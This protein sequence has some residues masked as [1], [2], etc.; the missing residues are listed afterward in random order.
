MQ[1]FSLYC[2]PIFDLCIPKKD[3]ANVHS[4]ISTKY[5]QKRILIFCPGYDILEGSIVLDAAILA[6]SIVHNI[7]P[8]RYEVTVVIS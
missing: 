2:K 6:G 3:L 4:P 5:L 1:Q 8:K 7:F